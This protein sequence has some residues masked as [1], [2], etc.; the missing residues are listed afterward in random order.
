MKI[1]TIALFAAA[2]VALAACASSDDPQQLEANVTNAV[3]LPPVE[4]NLIEPPVTNE[5]TENVVV[6]PVTAP[7]LTA[8]EQTLDDAAATGMTAKVNRDEASAEQPAQ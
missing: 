4:A 6:A 3:E 1:K 8:D 7:P 2:S 5:T